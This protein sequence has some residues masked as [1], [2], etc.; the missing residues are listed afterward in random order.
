M[1]RITT[2]EN[3]VHELY[4]AKNPDRADWADW[5]GDN[6]VFL[7]AENAASLAGRYGANVELARAAA[8][9]HDIADTEMSRFADVHEETS[10]KIARKL[11]REVGFNEQEI[12]LTVD[13]AIRYHSC[14]DGNIPASTEGKVLATADSQ[15]HLHSDFYI[16]ATWVMGK[17]KSLENVKE[18]VLKKIERDF[19]SKILFPEVKD[20][21]REDYER[22]KTLF[23]R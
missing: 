17:E 18:W 20:E 7:V 15:A 12:R 14:H 11:M 3:S 4:D 19:N 23:N 21:C 1:T 6:H 10:L 8:L 13:D 16:F 22:L 2:L 9:L 5:L